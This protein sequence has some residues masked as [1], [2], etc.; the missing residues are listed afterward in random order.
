[1]LRS[2]RIADTVFGDARWLRR[3]LPA[4]VRDLDETKWCSAG[5]LTDAHGQKHSGWAIHEVAIFA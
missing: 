5:T 3:L 4:A 2:G 1:M